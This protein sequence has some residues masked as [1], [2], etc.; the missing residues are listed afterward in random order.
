MVEEL[1]QFG[2]FF[3]PEKQQIGSKVIFTGVEIDAVNKTVA[4]SENTRSKLNKLKQESLVRNS[5]NQSFILE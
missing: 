1:G 3:S 4:I 2:F 5:L